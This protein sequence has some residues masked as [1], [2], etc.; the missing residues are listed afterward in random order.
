[1]WYSHKDYSQF[2]EADHTAYNKKYTE[3]CTELSK[4]VPSIHDTILIGHL[5]PKIAP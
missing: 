4:D 5:G 3:G 1:M 2:S